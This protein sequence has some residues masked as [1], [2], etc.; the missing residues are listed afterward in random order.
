MVN[1]AVNC[2]LNNTFMHASGADCKNIII[3]TG[4]VGFKGG[5]RSTPFAAQKVAELMGD[6]LLI[7]Q[8]TH[9]TLNFTGFGKKKIKKSIIKGLKIKN[10]CVINLFDKTAIAHNG[11]RAKKKRRL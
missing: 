4:L 5:K 9:V 2:T 7:N 1:L 3:S 8:I 11:C 10:L 6:R